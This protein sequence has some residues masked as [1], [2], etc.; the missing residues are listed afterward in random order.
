MTNLPLRR[1]DPHAIAAPAWPYMCKTRNLSKLLKQAGKHLSCLHVQI[2]Q[3]ITLY[4]G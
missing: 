1:R 4:L 2:A 3:A